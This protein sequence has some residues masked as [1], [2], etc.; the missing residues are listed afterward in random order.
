VNFSNLVETVNSTVP[1]AASVSTVLPGGTLKF[2]TVSGRSVSME[3]TFPRPVII[4]YNGFSFTIMRTN[5]PAVRQVPRV[6]DNVTNM[7]TVTNFETRVW[8]GQAISNEKLL[9]KLNRN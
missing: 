9:R 3:E 4:G 2:N 6:V 1:S 7:V 5:Y 8:L